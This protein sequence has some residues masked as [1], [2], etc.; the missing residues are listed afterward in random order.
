MIGPAPEY[1]ALRMK[2][3]NNLAFWLEKPN[4]RV[5]VERELATRYF[6]EFVR[7][8]WA[9]IEPLTPFVPG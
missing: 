7:Q 9:I 8:A 1:E 6:L 4:A 3:S 5:K 2:N